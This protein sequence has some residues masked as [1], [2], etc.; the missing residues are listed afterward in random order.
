MGGLFGDDYWAAWL[1]PNLLREISFSFFN[2]IQK[3]TLLILF[4]IIKYL[5]AYLFYILIFVLS[6]I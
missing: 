1:R 4:T 3:Q 5:L 2:K 6:M